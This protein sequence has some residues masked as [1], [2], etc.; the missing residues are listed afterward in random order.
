MSDDR[1]MLSFSAAVA[2]DI[3]SACSIP[4]GSTLTEFADAYLAKK[5]KE[6]R[7]AFIEEMAK[8]DVQFDPQDIDPLIDVIMRFSKA[9]AD[10]AAR[11]NLCLLA[12]VI[13]GLKKHK[14]LDGDK[15]RKWCGILE[16]LTRDELICIGKAYIVM[17]RIAVTEEGAASMFT[18]DL[19]AEL[20][21]GGYDGEIYAL[22]ASVSRTGLL[23]AV[24]AFGSMAYMFTPW[25]KELGDLASIETLVHP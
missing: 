9:V 3:L 11:E 4:G 25:L 15:F 24:S 10:G 5:R 23:T 6:A 22:L 14:A 20:K 2:A 16:G 7:D 21:S 8:G 18:K 17:K 12:K 19:I 1:K 13:A